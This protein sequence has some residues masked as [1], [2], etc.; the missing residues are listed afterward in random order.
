MREPRSTR[1]RR[2]RSDRR[3]DR[4][5]VAGC[6]AGPATSSRRRQPHLRGPAPPSRER[7][8]AVAP[9][10]SAPASAPPSPAPTPVP[11]DG[12][13]RRP[14]AH[15]RVRHRAG[16]GPR[17][18]LHDG[19][20]RHGDRR[21]RG[22][23]PARLGRERVPERAAGPRGHAHEGLLD[24]QDRGHQRGLR[25]LRRRR[26][27]HEPGALVGRGLGVARAEGRRAP[28]AALPRR[29]PGAAPDV[30]DLVRGRGLRRAGAA[31]A[32]RPRPSGNTPRAAR[33]RR[34]TR[35]AT[36]STARRP[37]SSTASSPKPVGS[38]PDRRELG[39]RQ[40]HGRQRDGVGRPTGSRRL[41]RRR[42]R[43]RTRPARRPATIKVE[44]GGWWGSNEFVARSAYRHYED[45]PTYGDKHIGFRVAS[46]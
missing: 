8:A 38:Y 25:G 44:K 29:R 40:R 33:S 36:R 19:H 2:P 39:R 23:E 32:C 12:P 26:R 22:A 13:D 1:P 46:Q 9:A 37:M 42:A 7:R 4:R 17:R 27:L 16:L 28:A 18:D 5:P 30:R 21:P 20:G 10:P 45:P 6:S 15:R 3:P 35:G 14:G 41:L 43:R 11:S 31:A 34:S 24:R